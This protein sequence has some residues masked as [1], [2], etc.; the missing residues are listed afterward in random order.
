MN[1]ILKI[2]NLRFSYADE[3]SLDVPLL[4]IGCGEFV[5]LLGLNG[6]GKTTLFHIIAQVLKPSEGRIFIQGEDSTRLD[7]LRIAQK[8]AL[9]EQEVQYVFPY[10]VYEVVMMGR[11]AHNRGNYF[12]SD[13]DKTVVNDALMQMTVYDLKDR[14]ITELSGGERRRVEIAR[15]LAQE[16]DIILLDEPTTFLDVKQQKIFLDSIHSLHG[17]GKTVIIVTHR[18]D[19][20]QN[21]FGR[22]VMLHAGRIRADRVVSEVSDLS[23]VKSELEAMGD[24]SG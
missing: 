12:E 2:E 11:F 16:T 18:I 1:A 23:V 5:Y 6:S 10:S 13:R 20:V 9:V 24:H 15:A 19:F 3:F 21:Y 22:V 14:L 4:E 17:T 7:P 8:I